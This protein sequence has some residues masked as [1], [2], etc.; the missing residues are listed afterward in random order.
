MLAHPVMKLCW[1]STMKDTLGLA[2]PQL[3]LHHR[4]GSKYRID[5]YLGALVDNKPWSKFLRQRLVAV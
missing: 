1:N 5:T 4:K 2:W 3:G